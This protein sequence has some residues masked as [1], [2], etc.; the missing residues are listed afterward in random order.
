M[1]RLAPSRRG[2]I[3]SH[4][5]AWWIIGIAA[6]ALVVTVAAVVLVSRPG[7]T[8]NVTISLSYLGDDG[9]TYSCTY[10]YSTPDRLPMP[11]DIA[12]SMNSRD[13]SRTGQDIYEWA[14]SHP[15][16]HWTTEDELPADDPGS[17]R[18]DASWG[19]AMEKYVTFPPWLIDAGDGEEYALWWEARAG[20]NCEDGLR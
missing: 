10:D 19:L 16:E 17:T 1:A 13:W 12:E 2:S 7:F 11:A 18:A 9:Q 6:G 14:K 15:A 3:R 4:R 20:S 8:T 5:R